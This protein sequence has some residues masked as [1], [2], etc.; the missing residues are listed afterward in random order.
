MVS[1]VMTVYNG[2]K[3]LRE[4]M[5]SIL[6]QTYTDFEFILVNDCSTDGTAAIIR[7]YSDPRIIYL[8]NE[9]NSGIGPSRNRANHEARGK[10]IATLDADDFA[11]PERLAKQVAFLEAHPNVSVCGSSF[12]IMDGEGRAGRHMDLPIG[13]KTVRTELL[14]SNCLCNPTILM[15]ADVAR[16]QP[17]DM[18]FELTE[19]FEL[20]YRIS[21]FS[22]IYNMPERLCRYRV[23][24]NNISTVK[25]DKLIEVAKSLFR[26]ILTD[27][28][29]DYTEEELGIHTNALYFRTEKFRTREEL[30]GLKSW[31]HKLLARVR[32]DPRYDFRHFY[33]I[34][35]NRWV[36]LAFGRKDYRS[37]LM[38]PFI[39]VDPT[40]YASTLIGKIRERTK[41]IQHP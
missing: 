18:D 35:M 25:R 36:T 3:Y 39:S 14:L 5:D 11:L 20:W 17:Y 1:V 31:F 16:Q 26:R 41:K 32:K 22:D 27:L 19:D 38:N 34:L 8:E 6:A 21:R 4:A 28:G 29:V 7:S 23:H 37:I 33:G 15:R 9:R 10:Y 2:E 13:S 12:T 40:R 24:Q 30:E